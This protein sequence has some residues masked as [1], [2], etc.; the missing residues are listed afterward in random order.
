MA[1]NAG[2]YFVVGVL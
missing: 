1:V 2:V